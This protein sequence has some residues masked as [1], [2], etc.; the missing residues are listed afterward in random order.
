MLIPRSDTEVL[1]ETVIEKLEAQ[2]ERPDSQKAGEPLR[3]RNGVGTG[4]ISDI[5][6]QAFFGAQH[7]CGRM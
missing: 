4:I 3:H 5:V 1:V 6:A 2:E 7:G